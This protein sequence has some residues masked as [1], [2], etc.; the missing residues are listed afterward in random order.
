MPDR[1]QRIN[2]Q[3]QTLR[4]NIDNR[5]NRIGQYRH[6]PRKA[7]TQP[8]ATPSRTGANSPDSTSASATERTHRRQRRQIPAVSM[9]GPRA[10]IQRLF[11][12][13]AVHR[14]PHV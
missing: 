7:K 5:A 6:L 10:P 1:L 12:Q 2:S 9:P 4:P 14:H 3:V 13:P 8:I 11:P